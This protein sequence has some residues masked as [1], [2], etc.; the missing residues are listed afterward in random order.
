MAK[1]NLN[2]TR[3]AKIRRNSVDGGKSKDGITQANSVT[4]G[5]ALTGHWPIFN[6]KLTKKFALDSRLSSRACAELRPGGFRIPSPPP[7]PL[8]VTPSPTKTPRPP[9]TQNKRRFPT[10]RAPITIH[11]QTEKSSH[12][13]RNAMRLVSQTPP[14]LCLEDDGENESLE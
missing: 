2:L 1:I 12:F 9:H 11:Y 7:T 6:Q 4:T 13:A 8:L 3:W 5:R 14:L 10:T